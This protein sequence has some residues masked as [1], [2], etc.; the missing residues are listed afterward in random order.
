MRV[1]VWLDERCFVTLRDFISYRKPVNLSTGK[2]VVINVVEYIKIL[3][4][5]F[6]EERGKPRWSISGA[7]SEDYNSAVPKKGVQPPRSMRERQDNGWYI[8]KNMEEERH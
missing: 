2:N 7:R 6:S 1:E 3:E 5:D 8:Y 4:Y